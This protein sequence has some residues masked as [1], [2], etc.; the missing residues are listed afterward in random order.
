MQVQVYFIL[1]IAV[2]FK[3]QWAHP[4][5]SC[6]VNLQL[7][8]TELVKSRAAV[9]ETAP[10]SQPVGWAVWHTRRPS[11][12]KLPAHIPAPSPSLGLVCLSGLIGP[13]FIKAYWNWL[14]V[15]GGM[16]MWVKV[17]KGGGG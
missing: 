7:A 15:L 11:A 10:V 8:P 2:N 17:V 6:L 9:D 3:Q 14:E 13:N 12:S 16:N 5:H 1:L 4:P